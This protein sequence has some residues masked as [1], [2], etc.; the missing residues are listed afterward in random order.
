MPNTPTNIKFNYEYRD[1]GGNRKGGSIILEC[2]DT[3]IKIK[4]TESKIRRYLFDEEFF[5]PYKLSIPLIHFANWDQ[6]L[7]HDWYRFENLELTEEQIT[8]PRSFNDFLS[9]LKKLAKQPPIFS[10]P[11]YLKST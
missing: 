11:I 4:R 5:Y 6:M 1:A 3:D 7:D 9:D 2:S 8:D 10:K